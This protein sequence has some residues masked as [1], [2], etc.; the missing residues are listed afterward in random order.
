MYDKENY[1]DDLKGT[2]ETLKESEEKN[3][4]DIEYI[5]REIQLLNAIKDDIVITQ[6]NYE[7]YKEEIIVSEELKKVALEE[8]CKI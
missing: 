4:N 3:I 5:E 8:L 7:T 2:L 1:K 6:Y